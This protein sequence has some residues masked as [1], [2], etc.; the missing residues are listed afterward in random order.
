MN[1]KVVF[2]VSF[3]ILLSSLNSIVYAEEYYTPNSKTICNEGICNIVK[4]S[5]NAYDQENGWKTI[6]ELVNVQWNNPDKKFIITLEENLTFNIKP[7]IL[8]NGNEK[9]INIL[10]DENPEIYDQ[11][12][13]SRKEFYTKFDIS[14][15]DIPTGLKNQM[16]A[17]I[18]RLEN[19]DSLHLEKLDN[20]RVLI[21]NKYILDYSDLIHSGYV[22]D[23]QN[24]N[25][26]E[27]T[28][29]TA[30]FNENND[31][32][33]DPTITLD[34]PNTEN[35]ADTW[36]EEFVPAAN[37]GTSANIELRDSVTG[38]DE[39]AYFRFNIS[40]L[41]PAQQI[42]DSELCLWLYSNNLDSSTEG[43]DIDIHILYENFSW[44]ET[45]L[46]WN[47][48]ANSSYYQALRSD[49]ITF[50]GTKPIDQFYCFEVTDVVDYYYQLGYQNMSIL[51]L[52]S[53]VFGTPANTEDLDFRTKEYGVTSQR[54]FLNITYEVG[55]QYM[56]NST[57]STGLTNELV[58]FR[59]DWIA[60]PFNLSGYSF[61]FDNGL[62]SF[63]EDV[64]IPF[65]ETDCEIP[66]TNCWSN[67]TK[68]VNNTDST[69]CWKVR[70]NNTED[71]NV[72][73]GTYCFDVYEVLPDPILVGT[74]TSYSCI[75][76]YSVKNTT[77]V[78]ETDTIETLEYLECYNGCSEINPIITIWGNEA[79]LCNPLEW[80]QWII[81]I[82]LI[83]VI[84]FGYRRLKNG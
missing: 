8:V 56:F 72:L 15:S 58:E 68:T 5:F 83:I 43:W 18:F 75:N 71:F 19:P 10:K 37:H 41:P 17:V 32:V 2:L 33:L 53:N 6:D 40:M 69:I 11:A 21:D 35:M 14:L 82:L 73:S 16:E 52:T 3:V 77:F 42:L 59:L 4:Y 60:S 38:Y 80:V 78:N 64:W 48:K 63:I 54:P 24:P 34:D 31:L 12:T 27:I 25:Y 36:A 81:L 55:I 30:N 39:E 7:T 46:N 70:S 23:L 47:N 45:G 76:D 26:L 20:T 28:N 51:M 22:L 9:N 61:I 67:V 49:N 62:G 44:S 13:V 79:S 29:L 1:K 84:W 74:F 50:D 57:N 65:N 66:F